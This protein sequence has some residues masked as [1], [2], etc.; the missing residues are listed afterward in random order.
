MITMDDSLRTLYSQGVI[1][2]EECEFRAED[3]AIMRAFFKS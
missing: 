2:R 3:K 1:T